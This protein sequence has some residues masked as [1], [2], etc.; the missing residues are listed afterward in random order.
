MVWVC[1]YIQDIVNWI[2]YSNRDYDGTIHIHGM[3]NHMMFS[4]VFLLLVLVFC[5]Y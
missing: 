3:G 4:V 1:I 5:K 2:K